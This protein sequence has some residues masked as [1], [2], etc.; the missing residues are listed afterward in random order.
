[1][2]G[3][4]RLD[5]KVGP[6]GN[7]SQCYFGS[8]D[9]VMKNWEPA[10]KGVGRLNLELMGF[11]ARRAQAWL[12]I[13]GRLSRCKT[14]TD[15]WGEQGKFWQAASADYTDASRRLMAAWSTC[16]TMPQFDG[17]DRS[18]DYMTFPDASDSVPAPRRGERKAA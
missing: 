17:S 3:T 2:S 5:A 13:P 7:L 18:R 11:A 9:T 15:F 12:E 10:W 4:E 14:P 6:L 16:A 8:L 1:M